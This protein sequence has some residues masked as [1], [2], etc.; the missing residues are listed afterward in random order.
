MQLFGAPGA[1]MERAGHTTPLCG[2]HPFQRHQ[3]ADVVG[4]V[5]QTDFGFGPRD[6]DRPY[7]PATTG[8]SVE[9]QTRAR[10]G[11][12]L[13]SFGGSRS[14]APGI[15]DADSNPKCNRAA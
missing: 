11:L 15:A 8:S 3:P 12:E 6:A 10:C 2:S 7:D 1:R 5:L 9:H 14:P 4:K 13:G